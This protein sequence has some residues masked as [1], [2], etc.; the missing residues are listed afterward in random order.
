MFLQLK[1]FLKEDVVL[2]GSLWRSILFD[3]DCFFD[4]FNVIN[5][6][7]VKIWCCEAHAV[8]LH[9]VSCY[10]FY[11]DFSLAVSLN[12]FCAFMC[13]MCVFSYLFLLFV[14]F[15][16]NPLCWLW[17]LFLSVSTG[18]CMSCLHNCSHSVCQNSNLCFYSQDSFHFSPFKIQA[19]HVICEDWKWL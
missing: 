11:V 8:K 13:L 1:A 16:I 17:L 6:D 15:T 10:P 19:V 12:S 4:L 14:D 7:T 2:S 3:Q 5:T 9:L 18:W